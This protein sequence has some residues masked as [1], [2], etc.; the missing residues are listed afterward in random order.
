V[1]VVVVVVVVVAA[2]AAAVVV[3]ILPHQ[4]LFGFLH[5]ASKKQENGKCSNGSCY[6][7]LM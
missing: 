2:V 3:N 4:L 1:V 5:G 7:K 6:S